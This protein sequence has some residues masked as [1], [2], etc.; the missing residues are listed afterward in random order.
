MNNKGF[1]LVA[2]ILVMIV[3]AFISISCL[4]IVSSNY[5]MKKTESNSN[6]VFYDS[7]G[8]M[9]TIKAGIVLDCK[10]VSELA[11]ITVMNGSASIP[12]PKF[13]EEYS[14]LFLEYLRE[15]YFNDTTMLLDRLQKYITTTDSKLVDLDTT[16]CDVSIDMAPD[17]SYLALRNITLSTPSEN[18][19]YETDVT[20]DIIITPPMYF[21]KM[22]KV[23][24]ESDSIYA[25]YLFITDNE[26]NIDNQSYTLQGNIYAG[27]DVNIGLHSK[28]KMLLKTESLLSRGDIHISPT[29]NVEIKGDKNTANVFCK[30]II[31]NREDTT[32]GFKAD[33]DKLKENP[34]KL[35]INGNSYIMDSTNI[36]IPYSDIKMSGNYYGY[37]T[38]KTEADPNSSF[39]LNASN[40]NVDLT[41]LHTLQ[42][43]G[44]SYLDINQ[45]SM[46][47]TSTTNSFG[48]SLDAKFMQSIYLVPGDCLQWITL[49]SEG[50]IA[51]MKHLSNPLKV[52]EYQLERK[53]EGYLK[54]DLT[55]YKEID[56]TQY[57]DGYYPI[58]TNTKAGES[59]EN[60]SRVYLYLK[61]KNDECAAKYTSIFASNKETFM[62]LRSDSFAYGN[63]SLSPDCIL[64]TKGAIIA[65]EQ[66]KDNDKPS[67][68]IIN[69]TIT[70]VSNSML[71]TDE[72]ALYGRYVT[73]CNNLSEDTI[74][75]DST[76]NTSLFDTIINIPPSTDY[77]DMNADSTGYS[78]IITTK[79]EVI[80]S[81]FNGLLV[82]TGKVTIQ[83]NAHIVGNIFA[84]QG[85]ECKCTGNKLLSSY[86]VNNIYPFMFLT[87]EY[88]KK[89]EVR[90][91]FTKLKSLSE[92]DSFVGSSMIERN[93]TYDNWRAE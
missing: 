46:L 55:N 16:L 5:N 12:E 57:C 82:T 1:S 37:S 83:E 7:D 32:V 73:L 89:E 47:D 4:T 79:D 87:Q 45:A 62:Q 26:L 93:V 72:V 43:A 52:E 76:F 18:G 81:S 28:C 23:I 42:L 65:T 29:S 77:R 71:L 39:V 6:V 10:E 21:D 64:R 49:N 85:I 8:D 30:N 58:I 70:E 63:V 61:F 54:V 36:S 78:V 40:I 74:S 24:T 53:V 75:V 56:L 60:G 84:K 91:Y 2:V 80:N 86:N 31:L 68:S 13:K 34:T 69:N 59:F 9:E 50:D 38:H 27:G 20:T 11:Y 41:G 25:K 15:N 92:D 19:A 51:D 66:N 3:V 44:L 48:S 90:K 33:L 22:S 35:D 17:Y 67:L 88:S 14:H